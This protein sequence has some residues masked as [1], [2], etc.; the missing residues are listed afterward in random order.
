MPTYN[1]LVRDRIPDI[2]HSEGKGCRTRTLEADEFRTALEEKFIEEWNEYRG[3][4]SNSDALEELADV[5][6]VIHGLLAL[7]GYSPDDLEHRRRA[8]AS[9]RGAFTHRVFLIDAED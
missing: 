8:K 7:H 9:K 5:L 2:I 6:E 1:K 3:A 4:S